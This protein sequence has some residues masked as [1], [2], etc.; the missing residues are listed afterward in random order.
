[1]RLA[2]VSPP[3]SD[4]QH[5][6]RRGGTPPARRVADLATALADAGQEVRV[7]LPGA[8][9]RP[10]PLP[11]GV[12]VTSLPAGDDA[13]PA[14]DADRIGAALAGAWDQ[15][16]PEVVHAHQLLAGL[17]TVAAMRQ[18]ASA[19]PVVLTYHALDT[20]QAGGA[21]ERDGAGRQQL[22]MQQRLAGT[23]DRIVT[24]SR[25][26]TDA[27]VRLGVSRGRM[28]LVP[29][30]VDPGW[31]TPAGPKQP[32]PV[33]SR[34]IVTV[35]GADRL[36][37]RK[38]TA[39]AVRALPRVPDTELVVLG[40]SGAAG[41]PQLR[42]LRTLAS[43]LEV[44]DRVHFVGAVRRE[45][46]PGWYRSADLVA[47]PSWDEPFGMSALEAM[48]CGVP[49]VATAVGGHRDT[50]VDGLTGRLVPPRYP[51]ALADALRGTLSDPVR[52]MTYAAAAHDRAHQCYTW[53]RVTDRLNG[54]YQQ[55]RPAPEATRTGSA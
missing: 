6:G 37:E 39:D 11:G 49:V 1:M 20:G 19:V 28:T 12:P 15:W 22:T 10:G 36:D 47:C 21:G 7:F 3:A 35:E 33:A 13:L 14:D 55:L 25:A 34:R 38:G 52:R 2:I 53:D 24:Q 18:V 43:Q 50:V 9:R 26:E 45:E 5:R 30:G 4:R 29:A 17:A 42:H 54:T 32:R 16:H 48:A 41:D 44:R 8:G 27:L 40:G 51:A 31:F 23:V 46:M